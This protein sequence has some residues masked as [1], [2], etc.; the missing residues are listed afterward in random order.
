MSEEEMGVTH[1][2]CCCISPEIVAAGKREAH[3]E[4]FKEGAEHMVRSL[5]RSVS[6]K[7]RKELMEMARRIQGEWPPKGE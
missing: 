5:L 7:C 3:D 1:N 6:P 2:V 4:G